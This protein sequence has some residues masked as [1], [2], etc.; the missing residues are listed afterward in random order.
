MNDPSTADAFLIG[1]FLLIRREALRS[2]G[3]WES[4]RSDVLG[5]VAVAR[6]A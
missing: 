5:D 4:V 6:R 2:I 1:P 3:G